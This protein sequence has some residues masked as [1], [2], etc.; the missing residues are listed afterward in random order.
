LAPNAPDVWLEFGLALNFPNALFEG[1]EGLK[2]FAQQVF[3][4][5]TVI[6]ELD[7]PEIRMTL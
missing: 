5:P 2:R 7:F 4:S 1:V 3:R 6:K